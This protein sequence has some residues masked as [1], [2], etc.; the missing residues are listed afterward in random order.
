[1]SGQ[2]PPERRDAPQALLARLTRPDDDE[3][4]AA[5]RGVPRA[6]PGRS[7]LVGFGVAVALLAVLV[8]VSALRTQAGASQEA[9]DRETLLA[10]IDSEQVQVAR[11]RERAESLDGEI[12]TLRGQ[13][14][15]LSA[16]LSALED[17]LTQLGVVVGSAP[18][19]G[20]GVRVSLDDSASGGAEG[21]ILDT[22]LQLLVNGLWE[23]GAEAIAI[24]GERLTTLSA[25][26]TAGEAITV[27][28]R[29]LTPPYAVSAVGDPDEIPARLL[30]TRAGQTFADLRANLGI[31]F[32]VE[33]R[34]DLQLPASSRLGVQQA[35][36]VR[37]GAEE[38]A[39]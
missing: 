19:E 34:D 14:M 29:S 22:D 27:N 10:R 30:E 3:Y 18:V 33:S 12:E 17:E 20:P 2:R 36:G 25:I 1:M 23:S 9:A 26:R 21:T 13:T 28:Y 8:T 32:E 11:V 35:T 4:A 6:L 31:V 5:A 16:D 15:T 38:G 39:P 7:A 24:N 37:V